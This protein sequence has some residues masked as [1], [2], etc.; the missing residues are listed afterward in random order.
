MY[1]DNT[2]EVILQRL[3]NSVNE[4]ARERGVNIDTR[5]GSLIRTAIAPAAVELVLMYIALDTVL[6]ESFADTATWKSLVRIVAE[7]GITPDEATCAVRKGEFTPITLEIPIGSRFSL[8]QLNYKVISKLQNGVY[9][10]ECETAG[11][12]GNEGSGALV[13]IDYIDG[14]QTAVLTEIIVPG[15]DEETVEHLR[16]RY[17]N[18]L[19]SQAFGGNVADYKEKILALPGVGGVKIYPVWAGGGTVKA[20]I[21]NSQFQ[22]PSLILEDMVQTAVDPIPNQGLGLGI[23]PIGHTVT[24]VS[25]D[26]TTIDITVQIAFETGWDWAS[27]L[28]YVE[29]TIDQYFTSLSEEWMDASALVVRISHIETRL[30]GLTGILDIQNTLINGGTVNLELNPD[31]IPVRGVLLNV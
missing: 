25:V 18:S 1:Q 16:Q 5:E 9:Q 2:Y 29:T 17:F 11:N 27:V 10:L 14:L 26:E 15:E 7:R 31:S 3:I 23:A 19:E 6:D 8:N 30:L 24:V 13:P 12:I 22:K 21:L 4:W 28:P 20:V